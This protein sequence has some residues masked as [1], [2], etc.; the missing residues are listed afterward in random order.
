MSS[1]VSSA[2]YNQY[3]PL[4][5]ILDMDSRFHT[6]NPRFHV[7]QKTCYLPRLRFPHPKLSNALFMLGAVLIILKLVNILRLT[8][9]FERD[10]E[11]DYPSD[12]WPFG[13]MTLRTIAHSD[14]WPFG[15][16]AIRTN[17]HSEY[18]P[19]TTKTPQSPSHKAVLSTSGITRSGRSAK[20]GRPSTFGVELRP[21]EGHQS[22]TVSFFSRLGRFNHGITSARAWVWSS[23][24]WVQ[25]CRPC[26]WS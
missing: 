19:V 3:E 20:S 17:D 16:L 21:A 13:L 18:R 1:F 8:V 26:Q 5:A 23:T 22:V 10:S 11:R 2:H 24:S 14:Q 12:H 7:S 25:S 9:K 15:L 4:P 6:G